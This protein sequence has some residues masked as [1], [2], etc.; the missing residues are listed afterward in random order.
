MVFVDGGHTYA[1]VKRDILTWWPPL[2]PD[3]LLCGHDWNW[4]AV[5][6]AVTDFGCQGDAQPLHLV[7]DRILEQSMKPVRAYW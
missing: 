7:Y 1:D 6:A 4:D 3:G 5:Q 2:A